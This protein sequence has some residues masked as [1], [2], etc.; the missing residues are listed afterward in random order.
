MKLFARGFAVVLLLACGVG[1]QERGARVYKDRITPNWFEN[2]TKFWYRNDL[3]GGEREF[4]VIDAVTGAREKV[5]KAPVAAEEGDLRAQLEQSNHE[6][7]QWKDKVSVLE[8]KLGA[9]EEAFA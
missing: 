4:I 5:D 3:P 7:W 6:V 2:N 1:A 9:G 8:K